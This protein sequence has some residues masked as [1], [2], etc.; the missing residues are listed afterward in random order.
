M[1]GALKVR[2]PY[3]GAT[4]YDHHVRAFVRALYDRGVAIQ[5]VDLPEWSPLALP[6][7]MR[8]PWF[9]TLASPVGADVTLHFS[10]PHQVQ[11]ESNGVNVNYT[12][13]EASRIHPVW[14]ACARAHDMV[15]VPTESS[16]RAWIDS[17]VPSQ[18][19]RLCPLGVDP[20]LFGRPATPLPLSHS[21]EKPL[22]R[23]RVRFLNVSA[24][25]PR[26]NLVG[27]LRVWLQATT[28]ADDAVFVLKV[29]AE[30]RERIA[31]LERHMER[32]QQEVGKSRHEAAPICIYADLLPDAEMPRLYAAATHY[33]SMS[34]G[35]GWDQPMVE[36]AAAGLELV[37]PHHSAYTAYLD[38]PTAHL[39]PCREVPV[40]G[41]N[42]WFQ[43]GGARW[44]EPREDVAVRVVR[45]LVRGEAEPKLSPRDRVLRELTWNRAAERLIA[46][47]DEARGRR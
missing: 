14:V 32:V 4:G 5:L 13:F 43:F 42:R 36:A 24:L 46:L 34:F 27:L 1:P 6:P 26:K 38:P 12:M 47:L 21:L 39:I 3:R 30:D 28:H 9:D 20:D 8:D 2:G 17:G 18:R 11:V 25:I 15:V 31:N 44:W 41:E 22:D 40:V 23:Y 19:V 10:M 35:E 7:T 37:A 45:S 29:I 33:I 16:R